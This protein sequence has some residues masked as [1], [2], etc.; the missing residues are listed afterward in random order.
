MCP[1]LLL[2]VPSP[3]AGVTARG[4]P[5]EKTT[6]GEEG[7]KEVYAVTDDEEAESVPAKKDTAGDAGRDVI[8]A[9]ERWR[10]NAEGDAAASIKCGE[11]G[12][13]E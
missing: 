3:E 5:E 2:S 10:R 7:P 12:K 9:R 13:K 1:L 11:D 8:E 6:S 4:E